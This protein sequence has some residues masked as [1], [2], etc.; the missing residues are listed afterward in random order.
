MADSPFCIV[1]LTEMEV[2]GKMKKPWNEVSLSLHPQNYIEYPIKKTKQKKT[3]KN[4]QRNQKKTPSYIVQWP[5]LQFTHIAITS[6][7]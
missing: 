3:K 4:K 7:G 6:L 1:Q 2:Q 5:P